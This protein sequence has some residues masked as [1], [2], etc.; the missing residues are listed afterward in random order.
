MKR[1]QQIIQEIDGLGSKEKGLLIQALFA[2]GLV[3]TYVDPFA[4]LRGSI[5]ANL[6]DK[7]VGE[8]LGQALR[9]LRHPTAAQRS[10]RQK[11]N[12]Q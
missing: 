3:T 6:S 1:V 9:R 4:L 11:G 7:Q 12:A 2:K 5:P 10:H 8:I